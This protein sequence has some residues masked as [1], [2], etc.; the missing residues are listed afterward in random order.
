MLEKR[1][2]YEELHKQFTKEDKDHKTEGELA[3]LNNYL[4][5][6]R[7]LEEILNTNLAELEKHFNRLDNVLNNIG[8]TLDRLENLEN[9]SFDK[10]DLIGKTLGF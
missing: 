9:K 8:S 2:I 7:I 4:K 10:V 5:E 3:I 6:Y 1:K